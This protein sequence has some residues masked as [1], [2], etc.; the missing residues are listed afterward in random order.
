VLTGNNVQSYDPT[1]PYPYYVE[2]GAF[3][4]FG[5]PAAPG[6]VVRGELKCSSGV[7]RCRPD[8]S[9]LELLA[10]G[11]RNPYGMAVA[12]DGGLYVSDND[13]EET[14]DR[15]IANDPDRIWRIR[16]ADLPQGS[17]ESPD[18]F[19]FPDI[20]GDGLPAW[21]ESHLPGRGTPAKPLPS[22]SSSASP[23]ACR[24]SST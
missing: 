16:T 4:P 21:H 7:W 22:P 23:S 12:E 9:G 8:G 11:V 1:S 17:V 20:C 3:K 13:V 14:G 2:T 24:R 18:W 15:A 6:E 19:G 5:V 10:W